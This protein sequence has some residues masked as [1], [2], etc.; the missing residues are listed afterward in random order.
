MNYNHKKIVVLSDMLHLMSREVSPFEANETTNNAF[1]LY[2]LE[3]DFDNHMYIANVV[4]GK[5]EVIFMETGEVKFSLDI[6]VTNDEVRLVDVI[7]GTSILKWG[8][9]A[10]RVAL[11]EYTVNFLKLEPAGT[12]IYFCGI[13]LKR[14]NSQWAVNLQTV[15]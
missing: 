2:G 4:D 5:L 14:G 15:H 1:S 9:Y 11:Y 3:T 6:I 8:L 10:I 13:A 12:L 7:R